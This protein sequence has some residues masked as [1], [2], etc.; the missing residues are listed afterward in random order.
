MN[1][2]A[3]LKAEKIGKEKGCAGADLNNFLQGFSEGYNSFRKTMKGVEAHEEGYDEGKRES[4][5]LESM[6]IKRKSEALK[7]E[8]GTK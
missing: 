8:E 7:K 6:R 2:A 1:E 3:I 5:R 4:V